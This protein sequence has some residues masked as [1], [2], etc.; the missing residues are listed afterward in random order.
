M[1]T[2][3]KSLSGKKFTSSDTRGQSFV[4]R[5]DLVGA[6][7]SNCDIRGANFSKVNLENA[8]FTGAITGL[9]KR[10][11]IVLLVSLFC[12]CFVLGLV[13][14]S[15]GTWIVII[16]ANM[17]NYDFLPGKTVYLMLI[18]ILIFYGYSIFKNFFY[19][20][21]SIGITTFV[22]LILSSFSDRLN[23]A[24]YIAIILS[25]VIVAIATMIISW[26]WISSFILTEFK[27]HFAKKIGIIISSWGI[28]LGI[29][30]GITNNA[31]SGA[32]E[33]SFEIGKTVNAIRIEDRLWLKPAAIIL[34]IS[35]GILSGW[36]AKR[37]LP[38]SSK[39]DLW[40]KT[41][42]KVFTAFN[43]TNF[44]KAILSEATFQEAFLKGS[45]FNQANLTRTLWYKARKLNRVRAGNIYLNNMQLLP[46]LIG[47][48]EKQEEKNKNFNGQDLR[49]V[50]FTNPDPESKTNLRE[51]QFIN[52]DLR[53]AS[54]QR[55]DLTDSKLVQTNLD[56]AKLHGAVLSGAYIQEWNITRETKGL[57]EVEC[58]HVYLRLVDLEKNP[59]KKNPL[60]KPD[61]ENEEFQDGDFANF[62]KP[63]FDTLDLY[64]RQNTDPRAVAIALRN[65]T[66]E[67]PDANVK[68]CSLEVR[69]ETNLLLRLSTDYK[70]AEQRSKLSSSYFRV[71]NQ[72]EG[73]EYEQ[74]LE[75]LKELQIETRLKEK[76]IGRFQNLIG[77]ALNRPTFNANNIQ[78]ITVIEE[79]HST[80]INAEQLNAGA[81]SFTSGTF[82]NYGSIMS[83]IAK[84]ISNLPSS[85]NAEEPGIKESL[86]E[87]Q[88]SVEDPKLSD[89]AKKEIL[90]HISSITDAAENPDDITLRQKA[91]NAVQLLE[92]IAKF[93]NP[94]TKIYKAISKFLPV[95]SKFFGF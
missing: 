2:N 18:T 52:A 31:G 10:W 81:G 59:G 23:M 13:S 29:A 55:V 72:I 94:L 66:K 70:T 87:L 93:V 73:L 24:L 88:K 41:S 3:K 90:E 76:I 71:Y 36:I 47:K 25:L 62:I 9:Q 17:P 57:D 7:F 46:W 80:Q 6:D 68:F 49:G 56:G 27:E 54:F 4:G 67:N 79:D 43:G 63:L 22:L 53:E 15:A 89:E 8:D 20:L 42:A 37:I 95:I 60:R 69:D 19:G 64:H 35:I 61:D 16:L 32:V 30:V 45:N 26:I 40:I 91:E 48:E 12:L 92:S 77:S 5:K 75:K 58:T 86:L 84:K 74:L 85:S 78:E 65:L 44:H 50:N 21:S 83:T 39:R 11:I 33:A 1:T 38:N 82:N 14:I 34:A 28:I 51:S